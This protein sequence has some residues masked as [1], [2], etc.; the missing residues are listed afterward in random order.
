M[1]MGQDDRK[2]AH[3]QPEKAEREGPMRKANQ[4]RRPRHC[5]SLVRLERD[6]GDVGQ[7]GHRGVES[8]ASSNFHSQPKNAN[9]ERGMARTEAGNGVVSP[10]S[11]SS[12]VTTHPNGMEYRLLG[13][14][15]LKVSA[16]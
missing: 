12:R 16:L 15:G 11:A 10:T 1:R 8:V 13:G 7:V 9:P 3:R 6:L 14:S 2:A 5:L 4:Q